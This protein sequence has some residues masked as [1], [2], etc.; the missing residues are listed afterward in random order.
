LLKVEVTSYRRGWNVAATGTL[1]AIRLKAFVQQKINGFDY[2]Y[3]IPEYESLFDDYGM[4][5]RY[6]L[7]VAVNDKKTIVTIEGKADE[8]FGTVDF[9][10]NFLNTIKSKRE[11]TNSKALDRMINWYQNYF[12][13]NGEILD[14]MY[15][16]TYWFAGALSDAIKHGAENVIMISPEFRNSSVNEEK[17]N[18]NHNGFCNFI[19]FISEKSIKT[20]DNNQ[21]IGV[22]KNQY[23]GEKELYIGYYSAASD[24]LHPVTDF[25]RV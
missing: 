6:D 3:I 2:D 1:R 22:I 12:K 13:S 10:N 8:G 16:L 25:H 19:T 18:N 4:P 9:G 7:F 5:R 11:S 14:I 24:D 20:I 17:V 23:T 21:I 15:Q